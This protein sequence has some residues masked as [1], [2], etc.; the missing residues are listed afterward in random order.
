MVDMLEKKS[1]LPGYEI[2][3]QMTDVT[4]ITVDKIKALK[5]SKIEEKYPIYLEICE[6][7]EKPEVKE[8]LIMKE[9]MY[10]KINLFYDKISFFLN[11]RY[12]KMH[13]VDK[14]KHPLFDSNSEPSFGLHHLLFQA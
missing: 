14:Y 2:I 9:L 10:S 11:K 4:S 8:V 3:Q 6:L 1:F 7:L 5:K 13:T 12:I